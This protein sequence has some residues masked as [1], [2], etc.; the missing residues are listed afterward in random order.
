MTSGA[1]PCPHGGSKV[2]EL[3]RIVL[4]VAYLSAPIASA[5]TFLEILKSK[6]QKSEDFHNFSEWDK[7]R[8]PKNM[9]VFHTSVD[10]ST[11]GACMF[12]QETSIAVD[13]KPKDA[14]KIYVVKDY[15]DV[16]KACEEIPNDVCVGGVVLDGHAHLNMGTWNILYLDSESSV[17]NPR[18]Y[19]QEK[20]ERQKLVSC[21]KRISK[22]I[23]EGKMPLQFNSCTHPYPEDPKKWDQFSHLLAKDL[24][25]TIRTS[26]GD[27][28][29]SAS[30]DFGRAH[31][32]WSWSSPTDSQV[33]CEDG[34]RCRY[35]PQATH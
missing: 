22:G 21:F 15:K 28:W 7:E 27:Y 1:A 31:Y 2:R 8:N 35:V 25:I 11:P 20:E 16:L 32:G 24:G 9:H 6:G 29:P 34:K 19:P 5:E 17:S 10:G 14:L 4:V 18:Y 23:R 33:Y 13:S 30:K 3:L 26:R 12:M